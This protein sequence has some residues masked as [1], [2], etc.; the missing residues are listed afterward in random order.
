[1]N[2][3]NKVAL[4]TGGRPGIGAGLPRCLP[5]KARTSL[6]TTSPALR[7]RKMSP[8]MCGPRDAGR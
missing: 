7:R 8:L 3:L 2:V 5:R 6:L 4:I 1:M